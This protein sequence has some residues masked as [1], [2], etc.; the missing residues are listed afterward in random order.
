MCAVGF[1]RDGEPFCVEGIY[2]VAVQ[3]QKWFTACADD[4]ARATAIIVGGPC[5]G[6]G[7]CDSVGILKDASAWA[8]GADKV[9]VAKPTEC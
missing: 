2:K 7:P 9:S 8:V 3:L 4:Q 6:D 1:D 5:G